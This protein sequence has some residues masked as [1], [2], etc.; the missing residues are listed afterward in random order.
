MVV[1]TTS[2]A[3]G[4]AR[5]RKFSKFICAAILLMAGVALANVVTVTGK[6][7][8][9]DRDVAIQSALAQAVSQVNGVTM[10][11]ANSVNSA[12]N[13]VSS[14]DS[15]ATDSRS[16]RFESSVS[17]VSDIKANGVVQA[18]TV[19]EESQDP[20]SGVWSVEVEAVLPGRYVVGLDPDNRRRMAVVDF[21]PYGNTFSWYGQEASSVEWV[22]ALSDKLN[23]RLTKTR[24]FSMLE[25]KFTDEINDELAGL[26]DENIAPRDL[27]RRCQK[28]ATDYL[29]V[30]EVRFYPV[31]A[32][33]INPLTGKAL[34]RGSQLFA[35]VTYRVVLAPTA[36]LKFTD[37][38]Q[39]DAASVSAGSIGEFT[40]RTTDMVASLIVDGIMANYRQRDES[41]DGTEGAETAVETMNVTP[42]PEVVI[43]AQPT[44]IRGNGTG[45]VVTPF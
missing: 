32:P 35:E 33:A 7:F 39:V 44:T 36:Q 26:K 38:I 5:M 37:I 45:G 22:K 17:K 16:S 4:N 9:R 11:S 10:T 24:R 12:A 25:R 2:D 42:V 40:S 23:V 15:T 14:Y 3:E 28:L 8:D 19:I 41:V 6:G 13:R 34:P 18:Y 21:R 1:H 43:P 29:V 27:I 20:V 31:S 30:G